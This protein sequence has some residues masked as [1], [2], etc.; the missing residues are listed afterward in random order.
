MFKHLAQQADVSSRYEVDSAG[1][2]NW[3]VG[4]SPDQRM[5]RVAAKNGLHYSGYARQFQQVDFD[6]FDLIIAMDTEN[7]ANL[8]QLAR[9]TE[10]K[11]KIHLMR[12]FDPQAELNSS[13]PDPYYGGLAGFENVFVIVK[14]SCQGLLDSLESE[15]H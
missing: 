7:Q 2:G 6:K 4:E 12:E 9:S 11:Q 10:D 1:T 14:R 5:R 15:K 13:V 8:K 3:H